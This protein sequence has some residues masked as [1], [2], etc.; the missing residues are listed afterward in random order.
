MF[1]SLRRLSLCLVAL[2]ATLAT[3]GQTID[4]AP[5]ITPA[6]GT[7]ADAVRV[8]CTFPK[9]CAGGRV[10]TDGAE[11]LARD[12]T[13]P[14]DLDYSCRLSAA[15]VDAEGHIITDVV[16][17]DF[18]IQRVTPPTVT[19]VPKEGVRRESF[20]VTRLVWS[21][22]TSVTMDLAAF[23]TGG[24]R[25]GENVVWLTGP[26]GET[27]SGGDAN[28][29]W[30]DGLNAF[31]A[32]VYRNYD[33]KTPGEYILHVA[34]GVFTV[35]GKLYEDELQL[36]YEIAETLPA[37]TFSPE[38]GEYKGSVTVT[39]EYPEDGSAFYKFYKLNGAKAK[40]YTAP[41]TLT[42]TSTIE[43]YGMDEDFTAQTPSATATYTILAADPEPEVLD[44]PVISRE[45]TAVSIS[46]PAGATL[47]YW[48]NDRMTTARLYTAPFALDGNGSVSCVA[49]NDRGQSPTVR[50]AVNDLPDNRGDKGERILLTPQTL[51]TAHVRALSPDGRWAVGYIGGD[52]SSRGFIWDTEADDFQYVSTFYISQLWKV[53]NDGTAYGWRPRTNDIDESM[54]D[55]DIL[56]GTYK[57]G[58][59]T[60]MTR[61]DFD[62]AMLPHNA[63]GTLVE[64]PAGYPAPSVLSPNGEWALLGQE[65]LYNTQSGQ[66]EPLISTSHRH[67][68]NE[69]PEVITA[70]SNDGTLF[71]T[72][73]DSLL[74]SEKGIG[75]VR[76]T[77]GRWRN[78]AD[79]LRDTKGVTLLEDYNL[80]S[81]RGVTGDASM[82]LF[83]S[84]PRGTTVDDAFTRGLLLCIDVPVKHL[85][86]VSLKAEQMS[87]RSIVKVTWKAPLSDAENVSSYRLKRNGTL[88]AEVNAETTSF[89][90]E[91]V[92]SGATYTYTLTA[93]YKD[94]S[95]SAD[96]RESRVTCLLD[97]HRP[98]RNLTCRPVG[99]NG[100]GLS[101][102]APVVSLP[103]LQYFNE[104]GESEPFGTSGYNAEFGIRISASDLATF[105]GQQIR[106]FQFL[107]TGQ[108]KSY[109]LSLYRG[110]AGS[111][112]TSGAVN[113]DETPFYTQTIDPASLNYGTVNTIELTTPQSAPEGCDLYVGLFIESVGNDNMLGVS[114]EGFR[115]GYTDLCRI[116][117]VHDKM[118]AISKNSSQLTEIVL[119]LGIGMASETDFN[120]NIVDHYEVSDNG[121]Y[122][123]KTS[124]VRQR[125]D[126]VAE[127][128]HTLSVSAIYRDGVASSPA[129]VNYTMVANEAA[130]TAVTPSA[131]INDDRTVTLSWEAP[132]NDDRSFIHWGDLTPKEGWPLAK[133]LQGFMA[134]SIYPVNMT[135]DYADDYEISEVF[136]CPTAEDVDY[137]VA[138]GDVEGNILA[139][140]Q[141]KD[142]RLGEINFV[143]LAQPL[144]IDGS[145]TYQVVVN[146]PEVEQGVAALAYDSSGKWQDGYS[147]VL[148]YGLGLTSLAEFVQVTERPNWLMGLVVR[149]KEAKPLPVV[150]YNITVDDALL[151]AAPVT[152]T[153][154]TT[155]VLSGGKHTAAVDVVYSAER[156][157]KGNAVSFTVEQDG[158][159]PVL[160]DADA[161]ATYSLDGRR[162]IHD[163]EGRGLYIIGS[164]K[165]VY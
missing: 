161:S 124:G 40:Q 123:A 67:S 56:W 152:A 58:E 7:Y 52:I 155:D 103:K 130:F 35:D 74:S 139:Y 84:S 115:S 41:L 47:K 106:T 3:W 102:D 142:L 77:D 53:D 71:G 104:E 65:Y 72:F 14:F 36:H 143:P 140:A 129:A 92:M 1:H 5:V 50:L 80:L 31:K 147:N 15:G 32:Y 18:T 63:D 69:R 110:A 99:L 8:T 28:N 125:L 76:T 21:H 97:N 33:Q 9:G 158:I 153:T 12:Y 44:A 30:Q 138:V 131:A 64:G 87:G 94:G 105:E 112:L 11:L 118:V 66:I 13:G 109:T 91:T 37:P 26:D 136:F 24:A 16:T 96:S 17:H 145:M 86:P 135:A 93:L 165:A 144:T 133:G 114:F 70:V 79:W 148:N 25:H 73:D 117:G 43:A 51:E 6:S 98:V 62:R 19:T 113:Y 60:E 164:R 55:A 120:A 126:A 57:D 154:Y 34:G 119:P 46:G 2:I 111:G 163:R 22:V 10:W 68:G 23:K 101:W 146:V 4:V 128:D 27:I 116:E 78:V 107:P 162:V 83:H 108:Q 141:P 121:T 38:G 75:L 160:S 159:T 157:V 151:T 132:R 127:G 137:E 45:G 29:L 89:Y 88:L 82:L 122:V 54:T 39:I 149:Q 100:L 150:G 61:A 48:L 20:Y 81:V 95:E 134:I 156:T 59:W 49:Y 90:D 85:A 42:E